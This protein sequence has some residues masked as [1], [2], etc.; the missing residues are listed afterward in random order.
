MKILSEHAIYEHYCRCFKKDALN[1]EPDVARLHTGIE[2]RMALDI[3][4]LKGELKLA[5]YKGLRWIFRSEDVEVVRN[6]RNN[7][8]ISIKEYSEAFEI[9]QEG[10]QS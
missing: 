4:R 2:L 3:F 10:S 8:G 1:M 5:D 9:L 7:R 6:W